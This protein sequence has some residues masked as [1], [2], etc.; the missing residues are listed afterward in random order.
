MSQA[1]PT[2]HCQCYRTCS[3]K[4]Q[5]KV[6]A[7]ADWFVNLTPVPVLMG[8]FILETGCLLETWLKTDRRVFLR[9]REFIGDRVLITDS[10][11]LNTDRVC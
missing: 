10:L 11:G 6:N 8:T 9:D 7:G 4:P 3:N 1:Y 5:I 2:V